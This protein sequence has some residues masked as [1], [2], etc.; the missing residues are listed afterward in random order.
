MEK[1]DLLKT[2]VKEEVA[3]LNFEEWIIVIGCS[4]AIVAC[5]GIDVFVILDEGPTHSNTSDKNKSAGLVI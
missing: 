3:A 1:F 2:K 5:I 4:L